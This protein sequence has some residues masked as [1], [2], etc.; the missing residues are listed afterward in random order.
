MD[1]Q[2]IRD[3]AQ[4]LTGARYAELGPDAETAIRRVFDFK[5]D[6]EAMYR[7]E[8]NVYDAIL[9]GLRQQL[10]REQRRLVASAIVPLSTADGMVYDPWKMEPGD[11][12][13]ALAQLWD[14]ARKDY[15]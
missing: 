14:K 10:A 4:V 12:Q 7:Q 1:E 2:L 13:R 3:L 6:F 5:L 8:G 11:C 9:A 15:P